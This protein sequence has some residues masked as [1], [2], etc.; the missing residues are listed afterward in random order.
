MAQTID[1]VAIRRHLSQKTTQELCDDF[2]HLVN[3]PRRLTWAE[4]AISRE[5]SERDNLAW[6]AWQLE[7]NAFGPALPH[8]H[9]GLK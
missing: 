1:A 7:G 3:Q 9:F 4:D 6:W 2:E 5:L 8:M